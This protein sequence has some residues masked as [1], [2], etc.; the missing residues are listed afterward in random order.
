MAGTP[1]R[2]RKLRITWSV[3]W[4]VACVLLIVL[5]VRSYSWVDIANQV[6]GHRVTSMKGK[7]FVDENF[8]LIAKWRSTNVQHISRPFDLVTFSGHDLVFTPTY[9]GI[10]I[11]YWNLLLFAS[12]LAVTPWL[13]Y[14]RWRFSLRTVLIAT[15]L[16]AVVLGIVV[17]AAHR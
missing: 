11:R 10:N 7:I 15:T 4:G 17:Y 12:V 3:G 5:W 2:F 13:P 6:M 8:F 1:M 14:H 9:S 16:V